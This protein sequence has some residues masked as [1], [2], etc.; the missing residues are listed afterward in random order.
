MKNIQL[1][2]AAIFL[3]VM[4][5]ITSCKKETLVPDDSNLSFTPMTEKGC[6]LVMADNSDLSYNLKFR[7]YYNGDGLAER[8]DISDYGLFTQKY[9]G[10]G[11]ILQSR[12][13]IDNTLVYTVDFIYNKNGRLVKNIYY[14]GSSKNIT[15][16]V[17]YSYNTDGK[18][19]K[20][21]SFMN[22]YIAVT[23][24]TPEGNIKSNDLLFGGIPV[25]TALYFYRKE[26]KNPYKTVSGIE[27]AFPYY[28]PASY[29][30][31]KSLFAGERQIMY[32][33]SG[34]SYLV[35][36]DDPDKT[37]WQTNKQFYPVSVNYYDRMS[38][39]TYINRFMYM[40]CTGG[41]ETSSSLN[42]PETPSTEKLNSRNIILNLLKRNPSTTLK[43]QVD[44]ARALLKYY[45]KL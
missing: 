27:L 26:Y 31:S 33:V 30:G 39:A 16:E 38:T 7:F 34:N 3:L 15:D 44:E 4:L 11:K 37:V 43:Q 35:F 9:N 13:S 19:I 1:K 22:D 8:W 45:P 5:L 32:D 42:N 21:Q 24:Y 12:Y 17:F 36:D 25:Y 20:A 29:F 2:T 18:L 28:T 23:K 41:I 6:Q 14:D 40:N 10:A